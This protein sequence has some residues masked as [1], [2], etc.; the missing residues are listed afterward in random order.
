MLLVPKKFSVFSDRKPLNSNLQAGYRRYDLSSEV[1]GLTKIAS[2][3]WFGDTQCLY[4]CKEN[5][6]PWHGS[7]TKYMAAPNT[8][9]TS[10]TRTKPELSPR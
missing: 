2:A 1:Q 6:Y 5:L 3:S 10:Q 8:M 9:K 4:P 7:E